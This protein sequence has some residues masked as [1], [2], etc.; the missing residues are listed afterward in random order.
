VW[1][2]V[3]KLDQ[4][5]FLQ[6]LQG[7][8]SFFVQFE[9][10]ITHNFGRFMLQVGGKGKDGPIT[11]GAFHFVLHPF[12]L[13]WI[14]LNQGTAISFSL[15]DQSNF[16]VGTE[17]GRIYKCFLQYSEQS[18]SGKESILVKKQQQDQPPKI[19]FSNPVNFAYEPH[20]GPVH[21]V[22]FSPFHRNLFISCG[23]DTQIRLY[24]ALKVCACSSF[25]LFLFLMDGQL[26]SLVRWFRWC[27]P[28]PT[29]FVFSGLRFVQ[30][31]LQQEM[32]KG[33][34]SFMT[35]M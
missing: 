22:C 7:W 23:S 12:N 24:N 26:N 16:I 6:L 20:S 4:T 27:H 5:W 32:E 13:D 28:S 14:F 10:A 25:L 35:C 30:Q 2:L 29:S 8:A 3:Q 19:S 31:C 18:S 33:K 34:S 21:D 1:T 11:G 15:E 17:G 9:F